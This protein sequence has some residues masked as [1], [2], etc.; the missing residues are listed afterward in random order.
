MWR[1]YSAQMK[2][3]N[4]HP[5]LRLDLG[6]LKPLCSKEIVSDDLSLERDRDASLLLKDASER[7]S[8]RMPPE[9]ECLQASFGHR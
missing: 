2:A 3:D 7:C 6:G 5:R 9:A 8:V 1:W 4:A